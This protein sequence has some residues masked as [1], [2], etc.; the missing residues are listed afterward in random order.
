MKITPKLKPTT[1]NVPY[2]D[3]EDASVFLCH[4]SLWMVMEGDDQDAVNLFTGAY[5]EGFCD[6]I[7]VPVDA[8]IKW[9]HKKVKPAKKAKK[10]KK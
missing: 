5:K 4:G 6:E 3:L 9:S 2:F 7:C 10:P 1:S 8:E